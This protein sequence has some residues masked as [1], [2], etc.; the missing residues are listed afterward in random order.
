MTKQEIVQLFYK[1]A[2]PGAKKYDLPV[3]V[4]VSQAIIESGWYKSQ[5]ATKYNNISGMKI[6]SGKG[7]FSGSI[8]MNTQEYKN[9]VWLMERADFRTYKNLTQSFLDLAYRHNRF[10]ISLTN[11]NNNLTTLLEKIKKSGY[12]TAP[13]YIEVIKK[14]IKDNNLES[15]SPLK[16]ENFIFWVAVPM[17]ALFLI[18]SRKRAI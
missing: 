18:A 2:L 6:G 1:A 5:L 4:L 16:K 3:S 11:S 14:V 15:F 13:N 9:N 17:A 8:N 7:F 12:A 10:N